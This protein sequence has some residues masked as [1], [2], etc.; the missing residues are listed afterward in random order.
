MVSKIF[1]PQL[2]AI[3]I[4]HLMHILEFDCLSKLINDHDTCMPQHDC[5]EYSETVGHTSSLTV[6]VE[7]A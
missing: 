3:I 2:L 1:R 4:K 7:S 5:P 6:A